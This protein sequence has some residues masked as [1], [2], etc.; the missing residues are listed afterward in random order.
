MNV[1][2]KVRVVKHKLH[3]TSYYMFDDAKKWTE[4]HTGQFTIEAFQSHLEYLKSLGELTI[5]QPFELWYVQR[6]KIDAVNGVSCGRFRRVTQYWL[7]Q[8]GEPIDDEPK[9]HLKD[10][11][12][13]IKGYIADY[14][15]PVKVVY[16]W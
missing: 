10:L 6:N 3:L 16:N 1:K 14:G 2:V 13:L 8:N 7:M 9:R 15:R 11:L 5:V 12:W 4:L